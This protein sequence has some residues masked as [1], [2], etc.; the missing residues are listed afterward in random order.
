MSCHALEREILGSAR[1]LACRLRRP[2]RN[3]LLF[4]FFS[5][6]EKFAMAKAPSP[7]RE[8]RVLPKYC[9]GAL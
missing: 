5:R 3:E 4:K 1:A 7:T 8:T 6:A 2:R 9:S